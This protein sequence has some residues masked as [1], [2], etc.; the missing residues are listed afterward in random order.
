MGTGGASDGIR[1]GLGYDLH[2]LEPLAPEGRGRPFVLGGVRLEHSRGPV[3]HSDGD[4]LMHA[5][6]DALLGAAGLADIGQLFPDDDSANESRDSAEFLRAAAARL[7]SAGWAIV[8]VDAVVIL[9]RPKIGAL[10]GAM[11]ANLAR[12]LGVEESRVNVKGKTKE[13][14]D[15][16]GQGLA[17][18]VHAV[19]LLSRAETA[20]RTGSAGS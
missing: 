19:A 15:A 16:A 3:S 13:E 14:V 10:K 8:N 5:V 9:Q 11:R 2:R 12:A 20:A 1:V 17:V 18:E 7:A 6:T 4:A